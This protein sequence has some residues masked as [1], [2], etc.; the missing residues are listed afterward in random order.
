L[1]AASFKCVRLA[2][3]IVRIVCEILAD[4]LSSIFVIGNVKVSKKETRN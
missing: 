4:L 3:V 1:S 2:A